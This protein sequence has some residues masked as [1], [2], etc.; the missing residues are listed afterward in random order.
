MPARTSRAAWHTRVAS[1][2]A[3]VAHALGHAEGLAV[4]R[5]RPELLRN[6]VESPESWCGGDAEIVRASA[7][8]D[9]VQM[10]RSP[11][12]LRS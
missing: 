4:L 6:F 1:P 10:P 11:R 8:A 2:H 12:N 9:D 7:Q 3:T 5:A